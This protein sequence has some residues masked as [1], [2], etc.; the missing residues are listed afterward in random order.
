MKKLIT[1]VKGLLIA[2]MVLPATL[3]MSQFSGS[4][5]MPSVGYNFGLTPSAANVNDANQAYDDWK[6]DFVTSSQASGHRRVIF[7]YYSG[8][9]GATD[10]SESVSEGIAYGML[11]AAYRGDQ[12][13]F[14]DLWGFYKTHRNFN[15]VMNWKIRNGSATG[16][17]GATDAELDAAMALIVASEQWQSDAY[18]NDAKSLIRIIREKEFDGFYLK[19]GDVFGG[20]SLLNPS[21][22]TPA[23]YRVFKDYDGNEPFW[24]QAASTGYEVLAAAGGSNGVVPDWCTST[25]AFSSEAG[26]Y[27]DQGRSFFFDAVRTPFR[28]AIDYLWHGSADA[29]EYCNK[30][31]TWA[32]NKHNGSTQE[33]GSKYN[34][35]GDRTESFHNATF[36][37]CFA[38]CAMASTGTHQSYLNNGYNDLRDTQVGYGEYFNASLKAIGLFVMTGNYFIPQQCEKPLINNDEEASFCAGN[39]T[40][41]TNVSNVSSYVWKKDNV[42]VSTSAT[43]SPSTS[44]V[45]ELLAT[46]ND[47]CT[48]RDK[49]IVSDDVLEADFIAVSGPGNLTVT[50]N[51]L[52]GVT[53]FEY[54]LTDVD[55]D[56]VSGQANITTAEGTWAGLASGSYTVTLTVSNAGFGC[57]DTD[58]IS[59]VV[60]VG[61]GEGVAIDDFAEANERMLFAWTGGANITPIEKTFCSSDAVATGVQ[62]CP[63]FPCGVAEIVCTAPVSATTGSNPWDAFGVAFE[64]AAAPYDL[65]DVPFVSIRAYATSDLTVTVK[66]QQKATGV[67]FTPNSGGAI[68]MDLTSTPQVFNLDYST[69]LTGWN[70]IGGTLGTGGVETIDAYNSVAGIQILPFDVDDEFVGTVTIDYIIVGAQGL[71]APNFNTKLDAN[72]FTDF[73]NYLPDFFP[74]DPQ[75]ASCT[76]TDE[77]GLCYGS[78]TDWERE[79]S[80]CETTVDLVVNSCTA[81]EVRWLKDGAVVGSGDVFAATSGGTYV[82]EL[83]NQGGITRDTV[84]VSSNDVKADFSATVDN[85]N[86]DFL[87]NSTDFHTW[88]WNFGDDSNFEDELAQKTVWDPAFYRYTEEGEVTVTLTVRDTVCNKTDSKTEIIDIICNAP[89][90]LAIT[91]SNTDAEFCS[92]EEVTYTIEVPEFTAAYEWFLPLNTSGVFNSDSTE[93][94]VTFGNNS[95]GTV[96]AEAYG[97]CLAKQSEDEITVQVIDPV[98]A[99]F[100]IDKLEADKVFASSTSKFAESLEWNYK[101]RGGV[102]VTSVSDTLL[103]SFQAEGTFN[104]CLTAENATC[105]TDDTFCADVKIEVVAVNPNN[106]FTAKYVAY[107]NPSTAGTVQFSETITNVI[108]TDML[109]NELMAEESMDRLDISTLSSGVYFVKSTEGTVRLIVE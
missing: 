98:T 2:L 17:N 102:D 57:S 32:S 33:V 69:A 74:N 83:S 45:Y 5:V 6:R 27:T 101:G 91:A 39:V 42:Q 79:V 37:S 47:G 73:G 61:D 43:L 7:D 75:Y 56:P 87:N 21:Y 50:N 31:N 66:L 90:D 85:F 97:S 10:K 80:L 64:D 63:V 105:G 14:D 16:Q 70:N 95:S 62:E 30:F 103:Y 108:I 44:G 15:G 52:G 60:T 38:M 71:P 104:I 13:L 29:L 55:G 68:Q 86:G 84:V 8:G 76:V 99:E 18:V 92:G 40:L 59:K 26:I 93:V 1:N 106:D 94:V 36:V 65:T 24:D 28:S 89:G 41:S 12:S 19:P 4:Y 81:E 53:S 78:V 3:A 23:Y 20:Q 107:P 77:T 25:G 46:Y 58:V 72:G 96:K 48:A 82:A 22:F 35:N 9:L 88:E 109:G 67:E 100:E 51:T 11:L 49:I 54:V 34:T